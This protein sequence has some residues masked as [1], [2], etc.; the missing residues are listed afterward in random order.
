MGG[1]CRLAHAHPPCCRYL[2]A[3]EDTREITVT[4]YS[5]TECKYTL[6]KAWDS[7]AEKG[8][9]MQTKRVK[10]LF[11]V[12]RGCDHH[13]STLTG[14]APT[15]CNKCGDRIFNKAGIIH[16]KKAKSA[17]DMLAAISTG[18][19]MTQNQLTHR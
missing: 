4:V 8:H 18:D 1:V 10:K 9:T 3:L 19:P 7:C 15:A 17:A 11:F 5:C 2:D 14:Y 13:S 6:E 12:C 16:R